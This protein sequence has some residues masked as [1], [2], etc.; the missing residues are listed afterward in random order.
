MVVIVVEKRVVIV[1][2]LRVAEGSF[3]GQHIV[4]PIICNTNIFYFVHQARY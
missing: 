4:F 3:I 1:A 2:K